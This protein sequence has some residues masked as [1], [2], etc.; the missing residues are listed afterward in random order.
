[1]LLQ[2]M[3]GGKGSGSRMRGAR[4]VRRRSVRGKL[5]AFQ[6]ACEWMEDRT[7]LATMLWHGSK[8]PVFG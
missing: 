8:T 4:K 5:W 1:M 6:P 3:M 7:L 2:T